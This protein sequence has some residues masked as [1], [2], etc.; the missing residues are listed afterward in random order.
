MYAGGPQVCNS[1]PNFFPTLQT[2]ISACLHDSL[3]GCLIDISN[4]TKLLICAA[5]N[6]LL[7]QSTLS[8]LFMSLLFYLVRP[9]T[10]GLFFFFFWTVPGLSCGMWDLLLVAC[11]MFGCSI[12][13][14]VPWRGIEP[15]LPALG[16]RV[17]TT[18]S[19]GKSLGRF[20]TP[21]FHAV[22]P[23]HQNTLP[24]LPSK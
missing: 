21:F 24:I 19:P 13:N 20:L 11:R 23:P 17:L 18:E 9:I 5:R 3:L 12:W 15:E 8:Q 1:W 22:R 16:S 6:W 4:L 14:L 2:C 10:L 7:S